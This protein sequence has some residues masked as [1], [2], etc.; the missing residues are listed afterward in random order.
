MNYGTREDIF[1]SI[2]ELEKDVCWDLDVVGRST[3]ET[4]LC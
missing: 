2:Y 1:N 3:L 4:E